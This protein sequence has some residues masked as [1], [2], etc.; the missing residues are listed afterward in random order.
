MQRARLETQ[1]G[2]SVI[3]ART[4]VFFILSI[5]TIQITTGSASHFGA[6]RLLDIRF[7]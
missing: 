1:G 3:M 2:V 7:Y 5:P 6:E 4:E